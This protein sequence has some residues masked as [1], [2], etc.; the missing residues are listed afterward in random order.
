MRH[1]LSGMLHPLVSTARSLWCIGLQP[2]VYGAPA[3]CGTCGCRTCCSTLTPTLALTR[4]VLQHHGDPM[5]L[6]RWT[7]Q[8]VKRSSG[9]HSG[10]IPAYDTYY[11]SPHGLRFRS[12]QAV[13][14]HVLG[15]E[16]L[17]VGGGGEGGE[18]EGEEG[19][20]MAW[21]QCD[22]CGQWRELA[23]NDAGYDMMR[24]TCAH[25]PDARFD[26]CSVAEDPRAWEEEGE[27]D[28]EGEEGQ[29]REGEVQVTAWEEEDS[30]EDEDEA[31]RG[32]AKGGGGGRPPTLSGARPPTA[33]ASK[34]E[35][36]TL[37]AGADERSLWC[38]EMEWA[39]GNR[40]YVWILQ[41]TSAMTDAPQHRPPS[42][43]PSG[44]DGTRPPRASLRPTPMAPAPGPAAPLPPLRP[45]AAASGVRPARPVSRAASDTSEVQGGVA[46][47]VGVAG[48]SGREG[49]V[50]A[51]D[52]RL[53]CLRG[54][55]RAGWHGLST[56]CWPPA[57]AAAGKVD[58]I[59]KNNRFPTGKRFA[60]LEDAVLELV[61][62]SKYS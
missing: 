5:V 41:S 29:G 39:K 32:G 59:M 38:C 12:R 58:V 56:A 14:E 24:W 42:E 22:E 46:G 25:N 9:G 54:A 31:R 7:M 33:A 57:S 18:S 62:H 30:E 13:A 21:V 48:C 16:G 34:F 27:E 10:N 15:T 6:T 1:P 37:R 35:E 28:E 17:A 53:D 36:G 11:Y 50:A 19:D 23:G 43:T 8:R 45:R 52:G 47:A 3:A 44:R 26:R 51:L 61:S 55:S 40:K 60:S 4:Y 2:L 20:S 49:W